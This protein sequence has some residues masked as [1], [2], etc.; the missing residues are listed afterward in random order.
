MANSTLIMLRE[1]TTPRHDVTSPRFAVPATGPAGAAAINPAVPATPNRTRPVPATSPE[2]IAAS[3]SLT[4]CNRADNR[5]APACD[6]GR[7][8]TVADRLQPK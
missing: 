6:L 7:H 4:A 2:R 3:P 1:R 8:L 5:P